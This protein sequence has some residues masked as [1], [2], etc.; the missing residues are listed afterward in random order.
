[1]PQFAFASLACCLGAPKRPQ[2][3]PTS[4]SDSLNLGSPHAKSPG[5]QERNKSRPLPGRLSLDSEEPSSV[6]DDVPPEAL[7]TARGS[8]LFGSASAQ[9]PTKP[10][11]P[12]VLWSLPQGPQQRLN[13]VE[14]SPVSPDFIAG[15][16]EGIEVDPQLCEAKDFL[17]RQQHGVRLSLC[18][19][20]EHTGL[21]RHHLRGGDLQCHHHEIWLFLL[22]HAPANEGSWLWPIGR[23][24]D[25]EDLSTL[26]LGMIRC[27]VFK[28]GV[29][30]LDL[31]NT[32]LTAFPKELAAMAS[33]H[34]LELFGNTIS[35]VPDAIANLRQLHYL[36]LNSNQIKKV[37]PRLAELTKLKWLSL[38]A[39][40]LTEVPHM[41]SSVERL[42]LHMN[43]I[44]LLEE[45]RPTEAAAEAGTDGAAPPAVGGPTGHGKADGSRPA[46]AADGSAE[47]G[48]GASPEG[49]REEGGAGP[50]VAGGGEAEVDS[51]AVD[52]VLA[53]PEPSGCSQGGPLARLDKLRVLSLFTNQ[54]EA[55]PREVF[56]AWTAIDRLSLQR[57]CL[58]EVPEEIGLMVNLE[59]LWLFGNQLTRL[60]EALGSLPKLS[61]LWAGNNL[62]TELPASLGRCS[63]LTDLYVA[64]NRLRS[65]PVEHVMAGCRQLVRLQVKNNPELDTASWPEELRKA[66]VG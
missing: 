66:V 19:V 11:A 6:S 24:S 3:T 14:G 32:Q 36:S 12:R 28:E 22:I 8:A 38:N 2:P 9:E 5:A 35:E 45:P 33:L 52:V 13:V 15:L 65:F 18:M 54:I 50:G 29:A 58:T 40:E 10:K 64:D 48:A 47:A 46:E 63:L 34:R 20:M 23:E 56:S 1:M 60:P 57:N 7:L 43:R 37:T 17:F 39:N 31:S 30:W 49:G 59:H 26:D 62:L 25:F 4:T 16:S 51:D 42:S 61:K 44:K 27:T 41:P 53:Q 21:V 55:L